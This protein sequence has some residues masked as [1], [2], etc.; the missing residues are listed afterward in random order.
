MEVIPL[1]ANE[2]CAVVTVTNNTA[3]A[4]QLVGW[5]DYDIDGIFSVAERSQTSPGAAH[6][7]DDG[8]F[9]TGNVP[10]MSGANDYVL[11]WTGLGDIDSQKGFRTNLRIRVTSDQNS[12]FFSDTSPEPTGG[13]GDGEIE[14]HLVAF[15][16]L[17][18]TISSVVT[19]Q[20]GDKVKIDWSTSSELFNVGFQLWA[21]DGSDSQWDKLHPWLVSTGSGNSVEHQSYTSTVNIPSSVD[22]LIALGISSVDNDGS[23]HY[24]GPF[25]VG[26]SYGNLADLEPITWNHVRTQT[27]RQMAAQGYIRDRVHGYRKVTDSVSPSGST[28]DTK[29]VVEFTVSQSGIYRITAQSLLNAGIDWRETAKRD[30][31]ITDHRGRAVVRYVNA[32]GSGSGQSQALGSN[33][34]IFFHASAVD[35]VTG[36]Y[37]RSSV[38]RME[39]NRY[40]ALNAQ[41]KSKQGL[42]GGFSEHYFET[43]RIERDNIYSLASRADDPW[44]DAV[45][46][47]YSDQPRSYAVGVA[48]ES[49]ALWTEPSSIT[50]GLSR[51]SHLTAVDNDGDGAQDAEHIVDGLVVSSSGIGGVLSLGTEQATGAGEW[52]LEFAVPAD[53]PLT[54]FD[55][56][57]VV[58][59]MFKAG[60]G[61]AFSEV[62]VDSVSFTYARP[63]TAK[64]GDAHLSFTP[65]N[66]GESGY[67]V[68]MPNKGWPWAFAYN[69][70]GALVRLAL[71]SQS[72]ITGSDGLKQRLVR[73]A[74]L[75]GAASAIDE[76]KYW[77][78]GR[79]GFLSVE[80]LTAKTITSKSALLSQA[81]GSNYLM[82]AHPAFM[83][84]DTNGTDQLSH[85]ANAKQ[86]QG[87]GVSVINYL[88]IVDAFG[89]GQAGPHGL[90]NY[91]SQVE[92][93]GGVDH[94]LIV[95]GSS[96][97]HT[98]KLGTGAL[99]FIPGHYGQSSYSKFTLSDVPYITASDGHLFATIGRW[100]VRSMADLQTIVGKSIAWSSSNPTDERALLI[101]ENTVNGENIDF[102]TAMDD[103]SQY[104][105]GNM[106]Q[107]RVYVDE[108]LSNNPQLN[109]TQALAQAKSEIINQLNSSP[110]LVVYNGHGTTSQLSNAGL[111][112]SADLG[113]IT[114]NGAE[115]WLPLSC[116]VTY[117]ESTHGNTLAYQL[118]FGANAVN[119]SGATLLSS[120]QGNI[121]TGK[122]ILKN[123]LSNGQSIGEAINSYKQVQNDLRLNINWSLLGDPTLSM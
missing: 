74:A 5:L 97:D 119:I 27:D 67:E 11:V 47:S 104:L 60:A 112:K 7:D 53:T 58:G 106:N 10:A 115:I 14:D 50:L 30:I 83:G 111:L 35:S 57:V 2:Y 79:N 101:A 23:E 17:P 64:T 6:P 85:Y 76:I 33:G 42:S 65:P 109:L 61:Y 116:Y 15:D 49:D 78:S 107:A 8:T 1:I 120:Q 77:V 123:T 122:A 4:A 36:L 87:Y 98:D 31:A 37:G 113:Q 96:Y 62:H 69:E 95:G 24:Y 94:I 18:V 21:L 110:Q 56:Q 44:L 39:Q 114:Q 52:H 90:T 26:V 73:I 13:A 28:S 75:D 84:R 22:D 66:T 3:Q 43:V 38:Y 118:L 12:G 59:G 92:S 72:I 32:R 16:T 20:Q 70:Q 25:E 71:E 48:V 19:E 108:I 89:G 34:E 45:M 9:M 88:D 82:I 63:Y 54:I 46:L 80:S 51:S 102:A 91:L 40:Q 99:T 121:L 68:T 93:Q 81:A 29:S 105:P 117:Y 103:V 55:G 86:N 100:P 41:I